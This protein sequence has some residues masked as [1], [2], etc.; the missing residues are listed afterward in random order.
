MRDPMGISGLIP[1]CKTEAQKSTA[2]SKLGTA[3]SR[4]EKAVEARLK[5]D[6]DN[7][8]YYWNLFFNDDFPRR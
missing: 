6:L 8:F 5:G 1:S 3:L 4:T 7:A 2:L